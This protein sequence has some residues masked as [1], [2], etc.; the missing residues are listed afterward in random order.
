[1]DRDQGL[2]LIHNFI[3]QLNQDSVG[4][5][6]YPTSLRIINW[7]KFLIRYSIKESR[8]DASLLAQSKIL[9]DNLEYHL[10]GNHLMENAFALFYAG[11][12]F[13]KQ[14]LCEKAKTIL[15]EQIEEQILPDGAVLSYDGHRFFQHR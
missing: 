15:K 3:S 6:P 7:I 4:L 13:K 14:D 12:Y 5:D 10:M 2:V 1:M 8:I 9:Y 11:F